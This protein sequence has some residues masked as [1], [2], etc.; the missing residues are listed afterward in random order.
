M[1]EKALVMIL[2]V[3]CAGF[4]SVSQSV[5]EKELMLG[6][7]FLLGMWEDK[8]LFKRDEKLMDRL[9]ELVSGDR[10]AK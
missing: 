7:A 10:A 3:L 6:F 2:L 9:G 8:L 4:E 1:K 5:W